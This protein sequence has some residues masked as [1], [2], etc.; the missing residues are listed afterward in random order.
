VATEKRIRNLERELER[1]RHQHADLDRSALELE[2][3]PMAA[4]EVGSSLSQRDSKKID[5]SPND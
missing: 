1:L 5:L 3:M 4:V 2:R